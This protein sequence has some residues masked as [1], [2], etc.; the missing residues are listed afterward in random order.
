MVGG[1]QNSTR[2]VEV[3][4]A[5][6]KMFYLL[7]GKA[8]TGEH[9]DPYQYEQSDFEYKRL[10]LSHYRYPQIFITNDPLAQEFPIYENS[11]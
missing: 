7:I 6:A 5:A 1:S 4:A 9:N 10:P 2:F 8:L 11:R 3:Y